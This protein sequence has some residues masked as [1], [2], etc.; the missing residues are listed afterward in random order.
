MR[1]NLNNLSK[2]YNI[3]QVYN[4]SPFLRFISPSFHKTAKKTISAFCGINFSKASNKHLDSIDFNIL[5]C[6]DAATL[7]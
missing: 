6:L 2:N 1:I 7:R 4:V 3:I 5:I